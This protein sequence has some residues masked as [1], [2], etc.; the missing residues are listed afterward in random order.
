MDRPTIPCHSDD[1]LPSYHS[2]AS[3]F[4]VQIEGPT[5]TYVH[6]DLGMPVEAP[7][8]V[9]SLVEG[10]N[11]RAFGRAQP[12]KVASAPRSTLVRAI[13]ISRDI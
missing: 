1:S 13:G 12:A 4:A 6:C 7:A 10:L 2:G 3:T 8:M 11:V 5:K 9:V